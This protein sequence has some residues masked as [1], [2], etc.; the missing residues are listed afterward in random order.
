MKPT[1]NLW[2][3]LLFGSMLVLCV[4]LLGMWLD[5]SPP[6]AAAA[7]E[8]ILS[9]P[10]A[11]VNDACNIIGPVTW[12][13]SSSPYA[14]SCDVTVYP[15]GTLTIE[16]GVEV[17][18]DSGYGLDVQGTI[19]AV[20]TALDP[21]LFTSVGK[22]PGDWVGVILEGTDVAFNS[23]STFDYVTI[24]YGAT[25][26]LNLKYASATIQHSTFQN[27][28]GYGIKTDYTAFID[29]SDSTFSGN[30][31]G[32]LYFRDASSVNQVLANLTIQNNGPSNDKNIIEL[33]FGTI[34]GNVEWPYLGAG[35]PYV[36][37]EGDTNVGSGGVLTIDP[38][39]EF[40]FAGR[41]LIVEEDGQLIADGTPQQP[42]TFTGVTQTPGS[43]DGIRISGSDSTPNLNS[44]LRY[45]TIEYGGASGGNI[46]MEWANPLISN[47]TFNNS[48]QYGIYGRVASG[49]R[50]SYTTITNNAD[51]AIYIADAGYKPDFSY[52]TA[53]GNGANDDKNAIAFGVGIL[54][55]DN[56][57]TNAG[58]PYHMLNQI[59]VAADG[60][61]SIEPGVEIYF[62]G[63]YALYVNGRILASGTAEQPIKFTRLEAAGWWGGIRIE[64]Y[65]DAP[66]VGSRLD[67]VTV[68]YG[69]YDFANI[70][71]NHGQVAIY[72]SLIQQSEKDG[73][74]V[75]NGGDLVSIQSSQIKDNGDPGVNFGVY[76]NEP[77][78]TVV[79]APN[80]YWGDPSGPTFVG[81]CGSGG[82]GSLVSDGVDF[83]PILSDPNGVPGT[84]APGMAL[85][86]TLEPDRWFLPAD[87]VM[88]SVILATLRN[89]AG[90]PVSGRTVLATTSLGYII[91]GGITGPTGVARILLSST[92]AGDA[93]VRAT[94]EQSADICELVRTATTTVTFTPFEETLMPGDGSPYTSADIT[95]G[96]Q[97]LM[98]GKEAIFT[99]K[100]TNPYDYPILVNASL[101]IA[102]SGIGLTYGPI[103]QWQDVP[104]E[105][106]AIKTLS[107]PYTP[108]VEGHWCF[109][110]H[111][112]WRHGASSSV[113]TANT[114]LSID[115]IQDG[116]TGSS[117]EN[118]NSGPGNTSPDNESATFKKPISNIQIK[119]Y[120]EPSNDT[121]PAKKPLTQRI[122]DFFK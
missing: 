111:Y 37:S 91:D 71:T 53:T 27:S 39:V 8:V 113:T 42:I 60:Q 54:H 79:S 93:L 84:L 81:P 46:F 10:P 116:G 118:T 3:G 19:T 20:G 40:Q 89:G 106:G 29:V 94:I 28:S 9:S 24:E 108:L 122:N 36:I 90:L 77:L 115:V 12:S 7:P 72:H 80:N 64:G 82:T 1:F 15:T 65:E 110:I 69:G 57:W 56:L 61:L 112:S 43:W 66:S 105:A 119:K 98:R 30:L 87:G 75:A 21:I 67:Y 117:G 120:G 86:L 4:G 55:G 96:P 25:A 11:Q 59:T 18:F 78:F 107:A 85:N 101:A 16:P 73:L 88:Q 23:G 38:G 92:D 58:L 99:V 114:S 97:P 48:S 17:D 35:I 63:T 104:I 13:A 100:F 95:V 109:A 74:Y 44:R 47:C 34:Y 62:A 2:K 121:Q 33:G 52:L 68:E 45:V 22:T 26:D 51:Y 70:Y 31:L 102:Q 14:F 103:Q 6:A 50:I 76:N 83:Q 32:A 5:F 49:P 41:S